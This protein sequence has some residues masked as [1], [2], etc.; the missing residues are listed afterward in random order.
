MNE[1]I[2]VKAMRDVT[3]G[4]LATILNEFSNTAGL[5]AEILE[6]SVPVSPA[7]KGFCDLLGLE[8]FYMGNEGKMIAVVAK[9][10]AARALDLVRNTKNGRNA[11]II[12]AFSAGKGVTVRTPLGSTDR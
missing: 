4:G 3:R 10:D 6:D 11:A 1:G 5:A 2:K 7:V 9:E 12:G 8:P